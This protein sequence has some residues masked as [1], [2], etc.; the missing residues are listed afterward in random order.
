MQNTH[1]ITTTLVINL[2]KHY[3]NSL[4]NCDIF[5]LLDF[6]TPCP[7][8]HIFFKH[9]S[10]KIRHH[11]LIL[12][13]SFKNLEIVLCLLKNKFRVWVIPNEWAKKKWT[14]RKLGWLFWQ[15]KFCFLL[16]TRG[17]TSIDNTSDPK[18]P[19]WLQ[20]TRYSSKNSH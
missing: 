4:P 8:I 19:K 9:F 12:N 18:G 1:Y 16:T 5:S 20:H 7:L 14:Q 13:S 2:L 17:H 6:L 15:L 3:Q 11:S 10:N